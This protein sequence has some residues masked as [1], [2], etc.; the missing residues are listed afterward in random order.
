[1]NN[2]LKFKQSASAKRPV[3][4]SERLVRRAAIA[5]ELARDVFTSEKLGEERELADALSDLEQELYALGK[6]VEQLQL[7]EE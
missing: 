5:L 4:A 1:M 7:G 2:V 6:L 3:S